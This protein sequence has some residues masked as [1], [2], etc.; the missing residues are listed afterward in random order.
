MTT[1][2]L[3]GGLGAGKTTVLAMFK[4]LGARVC[5]ADDLVHRELKTNSGLKKKIFEIFGADVFQRGRIQRHLL[6]NKVFH[7]KKDLK[8]LNALIHP[9]VKKR[10]F[11]WLKAGSCR[12]IA[13]AEV[14][15]L[16]EAGFDKF[17]DVT[18][19]VATDPKIL[20]GRLLKNPRLD[21]KDVFARMREQLP[22][23]KKIRRCDFVIDNSGDRK[24]TFNRV[25]KIM[26]EK[27]WKNWK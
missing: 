8:R 13:V 12:S 2:G 16:F 18:I 6:A 1:I 17:F 21:R 9:L 23:D 25:K 26:E 5:G 10:L 4:K 19:G 27:K 7:N 11:A 15:L 24:Q 20:K 14:P 3:T 22:A